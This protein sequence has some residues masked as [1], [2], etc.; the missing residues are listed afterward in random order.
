VLGQADRGSRRALGLE[1]LARPRPV[2]RLRLGQGADIRLRGPRR[3][4]AV[5][6]RARRHRDDGDDIVNMVNLHP[7]ELVRRLR[8]RRPGTRHRPAAAIRPVARQHHAQ[9]LEERPPRRDPAQHHRP[10]DG[11]LPGCRLRR[12]PQRWGSVARVVVSDRRVTVAG[13]RQGA[14]YAEHGAEPC[15]DQQVR[16]KSARRRK[17]G[18]GTVRCWKGRSPAQAPFLAKTPGEPSWRIHLAKVRV[19]GSNPVVRSRITTDT[20]VGP[21]DWTP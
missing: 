5:A 7:L 4:L 16:G 10:L 20:G 11:R 3:P 19:A 2:R 9:R 13:C 12:G 15:A 21:R 14:W 1:R 8:P 18:E 6:A 17:T